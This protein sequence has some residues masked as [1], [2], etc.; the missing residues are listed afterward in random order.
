[1]RLKLRVKST[2]DFEGGGVPAKQ[3][4]GVAGGASQRPERSR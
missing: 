1:M 3:A 4:G 2:Y